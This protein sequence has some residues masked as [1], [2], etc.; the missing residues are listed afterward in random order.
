MAKTMSIVGKIASF[1][2]TLKGGD[3]PKVFEI[4]LPVTIDFTGATEDQLISCCAGGSSAR[5]QLQSKLRKLSVEALRKMSIDGCKYKFTEIIS[6]SISV[7]RSYPDII[8]GMNE[9]DG[10]AQLMSD[11]GVKEDVAKRYYLKI[12]TK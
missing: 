7:Q 1:V 12:T 3:L 6:G 10:V 4:E 9:A 5:V 11:L 8:K 2:M